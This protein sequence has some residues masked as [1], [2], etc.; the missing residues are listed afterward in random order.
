MVTFIIIDLQVLYLLVPQTFSVLFLYNNSFL[1][2]SQEK[3]KKYEKVP[4]EY[5]I[6]AVNIFLC[7]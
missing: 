4:F 3:E 2:Y 6:Y 5:H 1:F 7:Q